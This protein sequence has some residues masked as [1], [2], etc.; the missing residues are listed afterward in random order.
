MLGLWA[1]GCREPNPAYHPVSLDAAVRK[2]A[3]IG[4]EP[5]RPGNPDTVVVVRD[6]NSGG[7]P[8]GNLD[9][10]REP[11]L[12]SP[13]QGDAPVVADAGEVRPGPDG[14][15]VVDAAPSDARDTPDARQGDEP[16]VK[17]LAAEPGIVPDLPPET[18]SEVRDAPESELPI[19][20]DAPMLL[21]VT[22]DL[23]GQGEVSVDLA[24]FCPEGQTQECTTPGNPLVGA[25]RPGQ[26]TCSGGIWTRCSDVMPAAEQCGNAL[27]DNCNG[28]TDEGCA[29]D[30]LVVCQDC[31]NGEADGST[32]QPF[33]TL[34]GAIV[35]AG[36]VD[37]G[38]RPR[39]CVAGGTSCSATA[40]YQ[41]NGSLNIPDGTIVQGSYAL[42]PDGL[43][44]CASPAQ[45][46]TTLEFTDP[47][48]G[49]VFS[50]GVNSAELSG[51]VIKRVSDQGLPGPEGSEIAGVLVDG[52]RN[53]S[54]SRIFITDAPSGARTYGVRII[55]GGQATIVGSAING[56]QG[57]SAVGILVNTGG[58]VVL[59]NNCDTL[60]E[61]VC[62]SKCSD[63]GAVLGIWG[64]PPSSSPDA[65]T[66][67][68]AVSITRTDG[69]ASSLSGNM[70][71]GGVSG[72][73]TTTGA[74]GRT[75]AGGN[76]H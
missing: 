30:C 64:R 7:E 65:G 42:T 68:L 17:D 25:C 72:V 24:P 59:R 26:Q 54:L 33:T 35:A 2:D 6:G 20:V 75:F 34:E 18:G 22:L 3:P 29:N 15:D 31:G 38:P 69:A 14:A 43:V 32:V 21:D 73:A 52:A 36:T 53:V 60:V 9:R 70:L 41:L 19:D 23:G 56:G 11:D 71:C 37:G 28:A 48:Q 12:S 49:V 47:I 8:D 67:T 4:G 13:D 55:S 51:F 5:D 62:T 40:S 39:I 58:S 63:E 61:G 44:Y 10:K 45:P 50:Q 46:T 76:A 16:S 1:Q 66:E 57:T 74:S 27:D